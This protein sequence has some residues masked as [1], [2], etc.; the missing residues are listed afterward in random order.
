VFFCVLMLGI[1]YN[2]VFIEEYLFGKIN[3][4][5]Q[6]LVADSVAFIKNDKGI[7]NVIYF[8]SHT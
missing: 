8:S 1:L 3:G 6:K 4:S 2:G 7:K 5:S